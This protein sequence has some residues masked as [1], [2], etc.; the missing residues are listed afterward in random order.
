MADPIRENQQLGAYELVRRIESGGMGEVWLAHDTRSLSRVA[1][2]VL[3]SHVT[4]HAEVRAR[5]MHD[6]LITA[7][8]EHPSIGHLYVLAEEG[9]TMFVV[10]EYVDGKSFGAARRSGEISDAD[11]VRAIRDVAEA[12]AEAHEAGIIHRAIKP[13]NILLTGTR[14][15]LMDLGLGKR[16][17]RSNVEYMSPEQVLSQPLD[18]RTDLFSLG[19]V[20]YEALTRTLP[21]SGRTSTEMLLRICRDAPRPLSSVRGDLPAELTTILDRCLEKDRGRRYASARELASALGAAIPNIARVPHTDTPNV[22]LPVMEK[23]AGGHA[24][25]MLV[26][27]DDPAIRRLLE[28]VAKRVPIECDC[29]TNGPETIAALKQRDYSLLFLDIMMP[30]IDGWGVLDFLRTRSR[31]SLPTLFIITAFLDQ[32][33]S[34]ADSEIVTGILYKPIDADEITALAR[35]HLR[36]ALSTTMLQKTRHRLISTNVIPFTVQPRTDL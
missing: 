32:V 15:K 17:T 25:R 12:L 4:D 21:F 10:L 14:A 26:A 3:S 18:A 36:G 33:V 22:L 31:E 19:A 35:E 13:D 29:A 6:A 28:L 1:I 27:D 20:L 9:E 16:P 23:S 30:R 8:L 5:L 24:P 34:N 7:R 2:R 11:A